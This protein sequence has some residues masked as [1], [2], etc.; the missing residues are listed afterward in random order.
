MSFNETSADVDA[1][2]Q[3][4]LPLH[5]DLC[6]FTVVAVCPESVYEI[7]YI[8]SGWCKELRERGRRFGR[9]RDG[10]V[11]LPRWLWHLVRSAHHDGSDACLSQL[12]A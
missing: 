2:R 3:C 9:L 1:A 12:M 10:A 6:N 7:S 8:S 4:V 5:P 11:K